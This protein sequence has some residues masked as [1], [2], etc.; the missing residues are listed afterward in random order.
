MK[1]AGKLVRSILNIKTILK[2][3]FRHGINLIIFCPATGGEYMYARDSIRRITSRLSQ[4][5]DQF[6]NDIDYSMRAAFLYIFFHHLYHH[7]IENM[8]TFMEKRYNDP[9]LYMKY[10]DETYAKS[11]HSSICVGRSFMYS[12]YF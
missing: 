5:C 12:I 8:I 2:K 1:W 11:L 3:V 6:K 9:D 7:L 10:Y 4:N